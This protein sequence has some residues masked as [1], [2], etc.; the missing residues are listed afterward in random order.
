MSDPILTDEEKAKMIA[1]TGGINFGGSGDFIFGNNLPNR[2]YGNIAGQIFAQQPRDLGNLGVDL[3][4][5][6]DALDALVD[7]G[8]VDLGSMGIMGGMG[9]MGITPIGG[10]SAPA[11][12]EQDQI[13]AA[14]DYIN[15]VADY[16]NRGATSKHKEALDNAKQALIDLDVS[17][18]QIESVTH[19][20]FP[21]G[22]DASRGISGVMGP[23]V[24]GALGS[25]ADTIVDK[26][27]TGALKAL[28]AYMSLFGYDADDL[29][30]DSSV[31]FNPLAP[32][33]TYIFGEDGKVKTTPLG[34]TS[35][36]NPVVLTG[37]IGAAGSV[38]G[39][40][41]RGDIDIAGIPGAA[42][43]AVG[44]LGGAAQTVAGALN[45]A[46]DTESKG[47]DVKV[48][49]T[50]IAGSLL[51]DKDKT[52]T[53]TTT[54][55]AGG[56]TSADA[57]KAVD[58]AGDMTSKG[59][60]VKTGALGVDIGSDLSEKDKIKT[61]S[62]ALNTGDLSSEDLEVADI[63]RTNAG[64]D[65]GLI[66]PVKTGEEVKTSTP[67]AGGV[68]G[69]GGMPAGGGGTRTISGGPGPLV[70][71]DYLYN[72]FG[73]LDQ[74]F[75]GTEDEDEEDPKYV[76]AKGGG[77]VKRFNTGTLIQ[78]DSSGFT[79]NPNS[80]LGSIS[81][82]N[83]QAK[84]KFNFRNFIDENALGI[85]GAL[86]GG[87]LGASDKG[88]SAPVGYQG[89]IPDYD[90]DRKLKDDAFSTVNPD[91]T[92][93]RPGSM[94]RSYFDYGDEL[95]TG[96]DTMQGVGLPSLVDT[97]DTDDT[98]NVDTGLPPGFT[99]TP[100][101]DVNNAESALGAAEAAAAGAV[102]TGIGAVTPVVGT[103][104]DV[105]GTGADVAGTGADVTTQVEPTDLQKFKTFL[106]P[107]YGKTLTSDDLL[108]LGG[109]EVYNVN[110]IG[111]ALGI[112]PDVLAKAIGQA[113]N[114]STALNATIDGA[115]ATT[116]DDA[117]DALTQFASKF[118]NKDLTDADLL[119]IA[120]SG[121]ST[122]EL[123]GKFPTLSADNLQAA[124]TGAQNRKT[125]ADTFA[126]V[127]ATDGIK[128]KERN[129]LVDLIKD[130][131][132][133]I[134]DVATNFNVDVVDVVA[135]L[136]NN[137]DMT[138]E[139]VTKQVSTVQSPTDLAVQLLLQDKTTPALLA[140]QNE[141]Y[142]EK[143]IADA[144]NFLT[145]SNKYAQGGPLNNYYL[146]G[147]TDG[148]ADLIPASIDGTQ[149]AA[150]SD[151]EFVI[152][153]DVVSHLGNGNSD[154]GANQLMSMMDRVRNAR[155]GTTKQGTE[156]DPMKMMPA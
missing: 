24:G 141:D 43:D 78:K 144:Y 143:E 67:A 59:D 22:I 65:V 77:H 51:G 47:N 140:A 44:G 110:Q 134:G 75:L 26:Y 151:G 130:K 96:T 79:L 128:T 52:T 12:T 88:S 90:F 56:A 113:Q 25:A 112:D 94:G 107:F 132:A 21:E 1:A 35:G 66:S 119:E 82:S 3:N 18:N 33:A 131:K 34:T 57:V 98:D 137:G 84:G 153:A 93:R 41:V 87:L 80:A 48:D 148:M 152:P 146:G 63:I 123:A 83:T 109:Q 8:L 61:G 126:S 14:Q 36:G 4:A 147:P 50:G 27:G 145:N 136:V 53:T 54:P 124:I 55:P 91:G 17:R 101:T 86:V 15:A 92:P 133:T 71:I 11:I 105:A 45:V 149:P 108:N 73:G 38:I 10:S 46:D 103:G 89:G 120:G 121:F 70:D 19:P 7:A 150:L 104:A 116:N 13:E 125:V 111:T 9:G 99:Y 16:K 135:D 102:D 74:P 6:K 37:P 115:A 129:D 81:G 72:M 138:L 39:D 114:L 30:K 69:I 85:A 142:T 122:T 31:G 32:G 117:V 5:N 64:T 42:V 118:A 40:L 28:D 2:D 156:I 68:G 49:T 76:Y 23:T 20:D 154:A 29:L 58:I 106:T 95:F 155:T 127:D 100:V 97:D 60:A 139:E 62:I